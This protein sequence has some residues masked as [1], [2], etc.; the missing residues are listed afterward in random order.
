MAHAKR[1]TDATPI[2]RPRRSADDAVLRLEA[3]RR[4]LLPG[5]FMDSG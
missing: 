2:T 4:L 1:Q 5:R 3:R